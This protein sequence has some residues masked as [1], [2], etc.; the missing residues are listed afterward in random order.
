V[1]G[2]PAIA[3]VGVLSLVAEV[4]DQS[5][6]SVDEFCQLV[7]KQLNY[8]VTSRPT[9]VNMSDARSKLLQQ[10]RLWTDD[11]LVT[12]DQLKHR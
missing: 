2:A 5:F 6:T 1:R 3:V 7:L 8:L 10:L 11:K 4:Y 12:A 9:A